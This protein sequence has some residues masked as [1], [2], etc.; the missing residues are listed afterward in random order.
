MAHQDVVDLAVLEGVVGGED[1]ASGVAEDGVDAFS[2]QAFHRIRDPV[3][4]FF[5]SP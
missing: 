2:L 4:I 1:C 3:S 5:R